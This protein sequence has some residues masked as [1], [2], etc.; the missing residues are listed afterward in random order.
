MKPVSALRHGVVAIVLLASVACRPTPERPAST[1]ESTVEP[2]ITSALAATLT[3]QATPTMGA[4]TPQSEVAGEP[5]AT[6][7]LSFADQTRARMPAI[8]SALAKMDRPAQ[9]SVAA[10][11][12]GQDISI[13]ELE[14]YMRLRMEALASQNGMDWT[15]PEA[16]ALVSQ[17]ESQVLEELI[18]MQLVR[19]AATK[20]GVVVDAAELAGLEHDVQRSII[21]I[22]GYPSWE[23][24]LETMGVSAQAFEDIISHS[25]LVNELIRRQEVPAQAE[26][27]HARHILVSDPEL[28]ADLLE[29]L[30][31]GEDLAELAKTYSEDPSTAQNGGDLGWFPQGIMVPEF[32]EAAFS[33]SPGARSQVVASVYGYHI[34]EVLERASRPLSEAVRQQL[35]QAAYMRWLEGERAQ[36]DIQ[37]YVLEAV[38]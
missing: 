5:D 13:D 23:A 1:A 38:G 24:Y 21:E 17:V 15:Q 37:R 36:A 29:R 35:Q 9:G 12:N 31:A 4:Q 11:V 22:H 27:V 20:D 18:D 26:Q 25:L 7:T 16:E 6:P 30:E 14:M 32:D 2:A 28:A 33:L 8:Q 34:I 3:A 10:T 19:Q